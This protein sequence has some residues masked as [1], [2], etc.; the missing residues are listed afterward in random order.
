[1]GHTSLIWKPLISVLA[2]LAFSAQN[3]A[4]A[5]ESPVFPEPVVAVSPI[6]GSV[7][8]GTPSEGLL[9]F[10]RNGKSLR[11]T[12][13]E[14][15][16]S[17]DQILSLVFDTS[18]VLYILDGSGMLSRYSSVEGFAPVP[19]FESEVTAVSASAD[20]TF[21]YITR[22]EKQYVLSEDGVSE[23][24]PATEETLPVPEEA[25]PEAPKSSLPAWLLLVLGLVVG[26]GVAALFLRKRKVEEKKPVA[27]KPVEKPLAKPE[28]APV[29]AVKV[30]PSAEPAAGN[31]P[32][33]QALQNS[34]FGRQV[35]D[36]VVAHLSSP[37]YGVEE[38]ARDLELSRI[39]VNRK[40]K[41]ETGYSPSAVFKF[42]RMNHAS[43][44]L[45]DG[46]LSVADVAR[47][48]GFSSA[49]YFSTAFK[50]Y[51]SQS[52]SEFLA[53]QNHPVQ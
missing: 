46:M 2:V 1:M 41:A 32:I 14:G 33:E 44:L 48:C 30:V 6:D 38:V 7:W 28:A 15:Q 53:E 12:A 45:L 51:Y 22:G 49:S 31:H 52:P 17:S 16:I 39:H 11:Y 10:G 19:S 5:S 29:P 27:A 21:I 13:E 36:L 18:G 34:A 26:F 35:W 25:E 40:L 8:M 9:R 43:R 3:G 4:L 37:A 23:M 47:E 24:K 42:I 20:H 50:D